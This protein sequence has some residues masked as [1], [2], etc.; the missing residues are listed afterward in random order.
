MAENIE[1]AD[2]WKDFFAAEGFASFDDLFE[3]T[4]PGWRIG[5]KRVVASFSLGKVAG[6]RHF[7]IKRFLHPHVKDMLFTLLSTGRLCSQGRYEWNAAH[8]L[9][10]HGI[11]TYRPVCVGERTVGPIE[12]CSFFITE[13][14]ESIPLTQYVKTRWPAFAEER[15]RQLIG[16][17]G[18]F[19]RRIHDAG[20]NFPDLYVWHIFVS[21]N[22]RFTTH[23]TRR[24]THDAI[25]NT[26]YDFDIIDLHRM[27]TGVT[28][29]R[30]QAANLG[31]LDHSM[32]DE[33]FSVDLRRLLIEAY[34]G[35]NPPLPVDELTA[36]VG[37]VSSTLSR[38][39][40]PKPY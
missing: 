39:R 27:A 9:L 20:I 6:Q 32:I 21:E 23:D 16:A 13:R 11:G 38:R 8:Y 15:K 30:K 19:V 18:R 29:P 14:L 2:N 28:D 35:D 37:R 33:F 12:R 22:P 24:T 17:V 25:R 7:F 36:I 3:R 4:H 34:A 40:R 5:K 10:E 1:F 31:R 26:Q